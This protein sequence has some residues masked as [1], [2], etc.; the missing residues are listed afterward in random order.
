M[1]TAVRM[2]AET[3]DR[4]EELQALIKLETGRKV[5]QQELL[6][7]LVEHGLSDQEEIVDA[8]RTPRLPLSGDEVEALLSGASDWGV[9][10]TEEEIDEVLY[11]GADDEGDGGHR[12][13]E[14][15][16]DGEAP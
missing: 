1:A 2:D 6:Q 3:K 12:D 14:E 11:G 16:T 15:A 4:L 5:T 7:R 8:F 13:G 10:T 9:E